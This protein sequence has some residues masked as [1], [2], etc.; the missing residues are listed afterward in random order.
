MESG[1]HH[2]NDEP[3]DEESISQNTPLLMN[4]LD[5]DKY[6]TNG[7]VDHAVEFNDEVDEMDRPW[8]A[9]FE[10]SIS[11]LARPN[12]NPSLVEKATMSPT[13]YPYSNNNNF[14]S[15]Y[16][17]NLTPPQTTGLMNNEYQFRRGINKA[18]SLDFHH[19]GSRKTV[20]LDQ[21]HPTKKLLEPIK[22]EKSL[23]DII[24]TTDSPGYQK[25]ILLESRRGKMKHD[26]SSSLSDK[27][28]FLQYSNDYAIS[29]VFFS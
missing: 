21:L 9:T 1:Q 24:S 27:A 23:T 19:A 18:L 3:P 22:S 2:S 29:V 11:L 10:R 28:S 8:P 15:P 12:M 14:N 5:T 17:R 7:A 6:N 13:I 26:H 25:Q 20:Y 4:P 16:R